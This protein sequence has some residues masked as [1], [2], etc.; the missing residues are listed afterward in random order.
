MSRLYFSRRLKDLAQRS[1]FVDRGLLV[2]EAGLLGAIVA[3]TR[4]M[5]V[6]RASAV[7]GWICRQIGPRTRKH[8]HVLDNL[9]IVFPEATEEWIRRTAIEVWGQIGRVLAEYPHLPTFADS[10]RIEL[11]A[12]LDLDRLR[13]SKVGYVFAAMHQAN[14]NLFSIGGHLAGFPLAVVNRRQTN[15]MVESLVA[16]FRD[17]MP[18]EILDLSDVPRKMIEALQRGRSVGLFIDHRIDAGEPVTLFGHPA[19]TTTVPARIAAKLGTGL[20]PARLERLPGVRFRLT[21][22]EPIHASPGATDH[23]QAALAMTEAI[24]RRFEEWV[25]LA[26]AD[27]CCVKRRWEKDLIEQIR[28]RNRPGKT[29]PARAA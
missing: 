1:T 29:A 19:N 16:R 17:R 25:R 5:G 10:G 21:V 4:G 13:K 7:G 14:W 20:I 6:E 26:P 28:H 27:W 11:V 8:A 9:R 23:R 12:K 3:T 24:H 15:P 22:E 2:A 18:C